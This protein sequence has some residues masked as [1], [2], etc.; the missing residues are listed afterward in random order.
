MMTLQS[1]ITSPHILSIIGMHRSGTSLA[2]QYLH[3][4]GIF[5]GHDLLGKNWS[6]PTCHYEDKV[7]IDLHI[8]ILKAHHVNYAVST[9][10]EWQ[11]DDSIIDRAKAMIEARKVFPQWGWKD[12]RTTLFLPFW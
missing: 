6:I 3:E 4:C 11:I 5:M 1:R 2:A 10:I 9:P 12:P 7:F 8:E